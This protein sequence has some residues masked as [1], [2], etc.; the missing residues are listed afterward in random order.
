MKTNFQKVAAMN[1]AFGNPSKQDIQQV[2]SQSLNIADELG[3]LFIAFGVDPAY[4]RIAISHLKA[5]M[6]LIDPAKLNIDLVRDALTDIQVFTYGAQ[7]ILGVDGDTDM[8]TTINNVMTRFIKDEADEQA[9]IAMHAAKGVTQV[10]F[11]GAYPTKVMKSLVDQP[12]APKGKFLKSAS[13][14]VSPFSPL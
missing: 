1:I 12:D 7:H 3:E 13:H 8:D 9:T 11:E 2:I 5:E 4:L 10:Y 14:K 6:R